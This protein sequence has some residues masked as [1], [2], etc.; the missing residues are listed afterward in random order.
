MQ[1]SQR[2]P[3][4]VG[5]GVDERRDVCI[6]L[7]R[8]PASKPPLRALPAVQAYKHP[9][10]PTRPARGTPQPNP[11]A[12]TPPHSLLQGGDWEKAWAVFLSMRQA[13]L[14]PSTISYNALISACERCGQPDRCAA[15]WSLPRAL[16]PLHCTLSN[17]QALR[18]ASQLRPHWRRSLVERRGR[19]AA[20]VNPS[21]NSSI[22][23][24]TF[25]RRHPHAGRWRCFRACSAPARPSTPSPTTP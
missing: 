5:V 15:R 1:Q 23:P 25:A 16:G 24:S 9:R 20:A 22:D 14:R 19:Q 6:I 4:W 21:V 17:L 12:L 2:V 7:C 10:P 13:G 3:R 11:P 18:A 8:P